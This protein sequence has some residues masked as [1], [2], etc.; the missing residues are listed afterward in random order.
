MKVSI[1][2]PN[3]NGAE[4]LR[5][6]LPAVLQV[7][8]VD[9]VVVSDDGSTDDSVKILEQEFPQVRVFKREKRGGF[10]TNVNDGVKNAAGDLIF[11][12]NSDAVPFPDCL[13]Y[14]LPHFKDEKVFAVSCS[15]GGSW[16]WAKFEK[17]YPWHYMSSDTGLE[18]HQ[19]LWA[20]GGSSVF[21]KD[22][23]QKLGGLDELFNPFY[24]EDVDLGFR[25]TKSGYVNVF[26]PK[27]KVE[28]YKQKGVIEENFSKEYISRVAQSNQLILIWKDITDRG[29]L[30]EHLAFLVS[31]LVLHPKYWLVFL[32]A[33][34]KLPQV[35]L[36]RGKTCK[37]FKLTDREIFEKF[38][39]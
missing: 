17:G 15:S 16:S 3:W 1:V 35:L 12:L 6:N 28:H 10:S 14:V 18:A 19:T 34:V 8:G 22:I 37:L 33:L 26:E 27:A 25:A 29:Y 21:R 23:W 4:K 39:G 32:P 11:L 31:N 20:S 36:K 9:E 5:K 30:L 2:I 38:N 24:E 13:D 7:K